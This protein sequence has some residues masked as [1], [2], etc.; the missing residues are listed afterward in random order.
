M[1]AGIFT[2]TDMRNS[3]YNI[4]RDWW[5]NDA[6]TTGTYGT[7]CSIT[8]GTW[9]TNGHLFPA[10]TKLF[11]GRAEN[12]SS[13][14]GY[15][16][17]IKFRLGETWLLLAEAYLGLDDPDKAADAVNEVRARAK[18]PDVEAAD[19]DMD[20]LLDERIR[21]LMGEET[22]RFTLVRTGTYVDRVKKHNEKLAGIVDEDNALWP[23]PQSIIDSNRGAKFPQ[24]PGY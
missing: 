16:D 9:I 7:K 2:S 15:K 14:G 12:L 17:R 21:E 6:A 20:F 23:I 18:A 13:T 19:M 4:K 10:Y 8:D 3:R 24:N 5:Y 11:A 22:R 1:G